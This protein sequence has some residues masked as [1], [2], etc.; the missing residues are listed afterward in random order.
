MGAGLQ[1]PQLRFETDSAR[2][3]PSGL[4]Q[5]AYRFASTAMLMSTSWPTTSAAAQLPTPTP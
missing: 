4:D 3:E 5:V 1:S 2:P